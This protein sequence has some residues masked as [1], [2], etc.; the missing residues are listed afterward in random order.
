MRFDDSLKTVLAADAGA[1]F[2]AQATWRQLVDLA[3]RGRIALDDGTLDRLAALRGTVP[4]AVRAASARALAFAQPPAGL[5]GFFAEDELAV[6]APV[7]RT[8]T[9]TADEWLAL[10]PQLS[11][12][13]RSVLRG[14]PDLPSEVVRGLESFG[15]TDFTLGYDAPVEELQEQ[16][17]EE[18]A[19]VAA[20]PSPAVVVPL[21]PLTPSPFVPLGEITRSLPVVAEA[22]RRA[23]APGLDRFEIADIVAR[24][25]A[26]KRDQPPL[27]PPTLPVAADRFRLMTDAGG[28]VRWIEGAGRATLVGVSLAHT[29][30]QGLVRVDAAIAGAMAQRGRIEE[31]RLEIGGDGELAGSWRLTA[32]PEFD[33]ASGRFVGYAGTVSRAARHQRAERSEAADGLRQLVHELRTPA[34]AVAGFAEFIETELLGPVSPIYRERAAAIRAHANDLIAAIDDLDT[35]ARI[36]ADALDLRPRDVSLTALAQYVAR[37]LAPLAA[38]RGATL[39]IEGGEVVAGVDERSAERLVAR[40]LA[41][42][43]AAAGA[44]ERIGVV[45]A[46]GGGEATVTIDRPAA[47]AGRSA[48][49]LFALGDPDGGDGTP[50]LGTGFTLRLVRNLARE[51]GGALTIERDVLTL[52]LP[53]AVSPEMECASTR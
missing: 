50:L 1:G 16:E 26:F 17:A 11:P 2:G 24:I 45:L 40:L 28:T 25:D 18:P 35:A 10:L 22:L 34:N 12:A 53:A 31:G 36:E 52:R 32:A 8:A 37:T 19:A 14:R 4:V 43:L 38:E 47:F 7:L 15:S 30:V 41:T 46:A 20:A 9:L 42:V 6:A 29:A 51:V 48:D 49:A 39:A 13:T 5:V 33:R 21:A 23:E 44:G 27:A 3:G